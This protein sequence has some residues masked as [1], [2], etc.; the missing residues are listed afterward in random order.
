MEAE[1]G[2]GDTGARSRARAEVAS[3]DVKDENLS[4]HLQSPDFFDAERYP[5]LRFRRPKIG[6]D[7]DAVAVARRDHD[8]GRH[9]A[10]S[11]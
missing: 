10:R 11:R 3:V 9:E 6:L 1:L 8:Q 4:A 2:V 5:A 7:G